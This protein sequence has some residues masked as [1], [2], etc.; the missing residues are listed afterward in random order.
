MGRLVEKEI[1]VD[2]PITTKDIGKFKELK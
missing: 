2:E 1:T